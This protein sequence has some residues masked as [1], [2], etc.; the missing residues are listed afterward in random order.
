MTGKLAQAGSLES[1]DLLVVI[2]KKPEVTG[3]KLEID[4][5][6]S[7]Q[8]YDRI[9][10]VVIETLTKFG[11]RDVVVKI[12]DRGALDCTIRARIETA[13]KRFGFGG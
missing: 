1:N 2:K 12:Q 3:L 5:I 4:S 7:N 13:C 6:V 8:Y 11:V 9:N 10:E